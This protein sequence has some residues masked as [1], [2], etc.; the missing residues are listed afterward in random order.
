MTFVVVSED[1]HR[2]WWS[3]NLP[4]WLC[5]LVY[6]CSPGDWW[7]ATELERACYINPM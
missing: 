7:S 4:V 1:I 2:V 5:D 3:Q 6:T